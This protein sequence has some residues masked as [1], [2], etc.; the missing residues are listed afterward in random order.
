MQSLSYCCSHVAVCLLCTELLTD[1]YVLGHHRMTAKECLKRLAEELH[2]FFLAKTLYRCSATVSVLLGST[3]E[4][5]VSDVIIVQQPQTVL[6]CWTVL[7][8]VVS[9][10]LLVHLLK[11]NGTSKTLLLVIECKAMRSHVQDRFPGYSVP[12]SCWG[13]QTLLSTYRLLLQPLQHPPKLCPFHSS[14]E[15][16]V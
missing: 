5:E 13:N 6:A 2:H 9:Q 10:T 7:P 11:E 3:A 1:L 12:A 4:F 16:H 8:T 15:Q 14:L